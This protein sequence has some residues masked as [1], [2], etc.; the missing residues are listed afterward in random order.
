MEAGCQKDLSFE[1]SPLTMS[2]SFSSLFSMRI[3]VF[4]DVH[5]HRENLDKALT[6]YKGEGIDTLFFCG[7]FCSPIPAKMMG[8]FQGQIHCVFGNGDGDRL[9]ISKVPNLNF[10]AQ[11][12]HA[13]VELPEAKIA[14]TH[15]PLYGDALARTG[16]YQAVF[17]G[18]THQL[19]E[20]R[21]GETRH[22]G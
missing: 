19:H 8:D 1:D 3:G 4:S 9:T 2:P 16:D 22:S 15:Y 10:Q 14:V 6:L 12:E 18:H 13:V 21:F 17:S 11:G 20:Q 5:D 7:D